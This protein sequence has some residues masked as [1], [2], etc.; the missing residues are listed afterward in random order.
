MGSS[1]SNAPTISATVSPA[2][3]PTSSPTISISPTVDCT[4]KQN[5]AWKGNENKDCAFIA[6][7]SDNQ[8]IK[9]CKKLHNDPDTGEKTKISLNWCPNTCANFGGKPECISLPSAT[10]TSIPSLDP[11]QDVEVK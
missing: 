1:P 8:K 6:N 10:P 4:D 9:W 3:S 2:A 7:K 11:V 5:F